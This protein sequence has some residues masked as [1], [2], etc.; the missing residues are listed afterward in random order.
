MQIDVEEIIKRRIKSWDYALGHAEWVV[1]SQKKPEDYQEIERADVG[2]VFTALFDAEEVISQTSHDSIYRVLLE[3]AGLEKKYEAEFT[4]YWG[5]AKK[6]R[7]A[8]HELIE[9]LLK[10]K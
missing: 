2:S 9:E 5:R 1:G 8:A 10:N 3:G 7:F 6:V 4:S